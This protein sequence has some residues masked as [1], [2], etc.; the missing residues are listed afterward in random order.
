MLQ[1]ALEQLPG[2]LDV[3]K[4]AI[5]IEDEEGAKALLHRAVKCV[6]H[7]TELWLT[8]AKLEKYD[9]AK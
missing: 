8:L 9:I 1:R 6:P 2:D 5:A 3:W 4:E 7:S